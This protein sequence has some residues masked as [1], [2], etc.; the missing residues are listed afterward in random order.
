[1]D[2]TNGSAT[3][4]VGKLVAENDR[5]RTYICTQDGVDGQYLLQVAAAVEYNGGLDRSA[6]VL[7]ELD[8]KSQQ[9]EEEYARVRT[10]PN[11]FLNY[12][13]GFPEVIDSFVYSEQGGRHINILRFRHVEDVERLV[14]LDT[15]VNKDRLCVDLHTSAWIMGK[16]LKL[17][18]FA[19]SEDIAVGE[20]LGNIVIEPN[21]HYVVIFDWSS[22]KTSAAGEL[23]A[24]DKRKDIADAA[25]AVY[26]AIGGDLET[27]D[28]PEIHDLNQAY[29][30]NLWCLTRGGSA[31]ADVA[32]RL[33]YQLVD[34]IWERG[35]YEFTTMPIGN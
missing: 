4:H 31:D 18:S 15:M 22:A 8:K 19:H 30:E 20:L 11:H 28:L 32:H 29:V 23:P 24:A 2:V 33:F 3:Y 13:L 35:F 17:L 26:M 34:S 25:K 16:S 14:P 27:G 12:D 9:L 7:R 1:M 5:Y 10:S 6:Y 21:E